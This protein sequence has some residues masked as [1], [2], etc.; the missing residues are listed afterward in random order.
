MTPMVTK[1]AT[2]NSHSVKIRQ[3]AAATS[4]NLPTQFILA[5]IKPS[6]AAASA[7]TASN[8][9]NVTTTISSTLAFPISKAG[10]YTKMKGTMNPASA[11][12]HE[13][14]PVRW[15]SEPAMPAPAKAANA[16]GGVRFAI[17]PK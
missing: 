16:T 6:V 1:P 10:L 5:K 4:N 8:V 2:M 13:I 9:V 3:I 12:L 15:G 11:S 7:I 17:T 14:Q